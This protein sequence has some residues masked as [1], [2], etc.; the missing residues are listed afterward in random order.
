M[1]KTKFNGGGL[2]AVLL[3]VVF[4]GAALSGLMY[5]NY[6]LDEDSDC[7]NGAVLDGGECSKYPYHD[8]N[9][10]SP[11]P[12]NERWTNDETDYKTPYDVFADAI[13]D[14]CDNFNECT[15]SSQNFKSQIDS[16]CF[17]ESFTLNGFMPFPGNIA[18]IIIQYEYESGFN[19]GAS[20]S[21]IQ[22]ICYPSGPGSFVSGDLPTLQVPE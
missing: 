2:F 16:F 9:G 20:I 15:P 11:T 22:T 18:Q 17:V 21:M 10:N 13:R 14:N 1:E 3:G 4:I 7:D 12:I 5:D 19:M 8:G 6:W